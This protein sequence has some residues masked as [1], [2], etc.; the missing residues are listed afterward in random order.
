MVKN[1]VEIEAFDV[2]LYRW[3]PDKM[4]A[5]KMVQFYILCTL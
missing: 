1:Y 3:W 2:K 5:D 4:V